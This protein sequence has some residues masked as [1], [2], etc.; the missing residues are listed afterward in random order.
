MP[1]AFTKSGVWFVAKDVDKFIRDVGRAASAQDK[2]SK[3]QDQLADAQKR[4]ETRAAL[5]TQ[6]Y[7]EQQ[8]VLER[9]SNIVRNAAIGLGALGAAGLV[10][11]GSATKLA[12]R[13]ETLGVVTT[14][15]GKNVGVT[16]KQMR[17]LEQRVKSK[18]IT[19]QATRESIA[20]MI[21]AEI[22]LA[23]AT[24]LARLAQDAAVIANE[25][26]SEAFRRLVFVITSGNVRM[27]RTLGLQVSFER[28]Y[29]RM[30]DSLG[31]T[32]DALTE[33][34]RVQART[35]E[36]LSAGR[37]IVGTY[38]A[39][40]T[41]AG[42]KVLSLD[43]HI[44][45]S[46]R[47]I[48]EAYTP[49]FADL[50]DMVTN[51][52]KAFEGA[53]PA[54]QR[55]IAVMIG[56]G[57]AALVLIGGVVALTIKIGGLTGAVGALSAAMT[58]LAANP[59][60]LLIAAIAAVGVALVGYSAKAKKAREDTEALKREMLAEGKSTEEVNEAIE[61]YADQ[62]GIA[63]KRDTDYARIK[64]GAINPAL[65]QQRHGIE[66][67]TESQAEEIRKQQDLTQE[68]QSADRAMLNQASLMQGILN[69]AYQELIENNRR[70]QEE[71]AGLADS[72]VQQ[73][74]ALQTG[75]EAWDAVNTK[76]SSTIQTMKETVKWM[77]GGGLQIQQAAQLIQQSFIAG[78]ISGDQTIDLLNQI[79]L[80]ALALEEDI[81]VKSTLEAN[82]EA[83][84]EFGS[85]WGNVWKDLEEGRLSIPQLL[86]TITSGILGMQAETQ[87]LPENID[88]LMT[89]LGEEVRLPE[90][91]EEIPQPVLDAVTD[92]TGQW[93]GAKKVIQ[94]VQREVEAIPKEVRTKLIVAVRAFIQ[95]I[96]GMGG[97]SPGPQH[98]GDFRVRG[99]PGPDRNLVT[100]P[101]SAG[102]IIRV[103]PS[104]SQ[105]V[106]SSRSVSIGEVHNH[107]R[108]DDYS[109]DQ[110]MRRWLGA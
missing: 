87:K 97:G 7:R 54:V 22:D 80:A 55:S 100:L 101:V 86:D 43:R 74:N 104:P 20:L 57:S 67:L 60:I 23:H 52:L 102:E 66:L 70:S 103:L 35:N 6:K 63:I 47:L 73:R 65:A 11:T 82:R 24:E 10:A 34:Q 8:A 53:N 68:M 78:I 89:M 18:G 69:P 30:A 37:T 1:E 61:E 13:V 21:Q 93:E 75:N 109:F 91:L 49:A 90:Q 16:E 56:A 27:A 32:T 42:K 36:V 28:A 59:V 5:L 14:Q 76:M 107:N 72:F 41:T 12:A 29:K 106:D 2:L 84:R 64:G 44:E 81:G 94:D 99:T 96:E 58:F 108:V 39:A 77:V 110:A 88:Q 50:V 51:L 4:M 48:G 19:L 92:Y 79:G 83:I 46:R 71:I 45:E 33:Q 105:S 26:S 17:V 3:S 9:G 98:G 95:S 62:A 40:M 38:E 25:N 85:E 15:L 31:V